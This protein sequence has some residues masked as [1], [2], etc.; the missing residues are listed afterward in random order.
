RLAVDETGLLISGGAAV[1]T[2]GLSILAR[3][4]WDRLSRSKT[5][6]QDAS[7]RAIEE[8]G[9]RFPDLAIEGLDRIE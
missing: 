5:P 9:D 1:A 3:G 4:V 7:Q 6:C 8:L 2:A